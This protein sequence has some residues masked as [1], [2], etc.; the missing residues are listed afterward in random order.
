MLNAVLFDLDGTLIDTNELV[1]DSFKYTFNA[2]NKPSPSRQEIIKC[3]GEPLIVTMSNFFDDVHEAIRIY[4]EF[5][6]KHHDE[7][8]AL[9]NNVEET[10]CDLRKRGYKLGVV[11]SKNKSTAYRGLEHF[12]ILNYFDVLVSSDDVKNPKPHE[13]PVLTA[14]KSLNIDPKKAIMIGDSVYDIISG[15]NAGSKTCGVLYSFMKDELLNIKADYYISDLI[16]ILDIVS[17][18]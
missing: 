8:I 9:Y 12:N 2:L 10:L 17:K 1:I 7:R 11:T 5:N 4:R 14:C 16:E 6:L 15:K 13:E 18:N 3:F